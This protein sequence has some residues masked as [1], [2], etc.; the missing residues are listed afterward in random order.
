MVMTL[1]EVGTLSG[2]RH[3]RS[4]EELRHVLF[5]S[6]PVEKTDSI[7]AVILDK[8]G[9][10]TD[11]RRQI[12]AGL[13][14][15][16]GQHENPSMGIR[17]DFDMDDVYRMFGLAPKFNDGIRPILAL[18][19]VNLEAQGNGHSPAQKLGQ[20]VGGVG[21]V[22]TL[23]ELIERH[24]DGSRDASYYEAKANAMYW[25]N[26]TDGFFHRPDAKTYIR[27]YS[28]E[29]GNSR[30]SVIA[31]LNAGVPVAVVT[32]APNHD[33]EAAGFSEQE[34][35]RLVVITRGDM[36]EKKMKPDRLGMDL[37]IQRLMEMHEVSIASGR[38]FYVGDTRS[39]VRFAV[40]GGVIPVGVTGGMGSAVH[41]EEEHPHVLIVDDLPQL[42]N[43]LLRA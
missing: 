13:D 11:I 18:I 10:L 23:D 21:A 8:D 12:D 38:S 28:S 16:F 7:G 6:T 26:E 17:Y 27:P 3:A 1:S 20:I 9:V 33:L 36:G 41:F 19:A 5:R 14:F 43:G 42:A 22:D 2:Q 31:L 32:N 30:D 29:H 24:I 25:W 37:A 34:I 4:V 40:N 35:A 15:H 39:D